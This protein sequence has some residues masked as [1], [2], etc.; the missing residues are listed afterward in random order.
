MNAYDQLSRYI[1]KISSSGTNKIV[2]STDLHF[3]MYEFTRTR[4]K[5]YHVHCITFISMWF[6]TTHSVMTCIAFLQCPI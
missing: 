5:I 4:Y 3:T 2:I 6:V 1:E